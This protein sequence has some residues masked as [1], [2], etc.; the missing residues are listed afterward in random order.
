MTIFPFPDAYSTLNNTK[1]VDEE[2]YKQEAPAV[3]IREDQREENFRLDIN[4]WDIN[5]HQKPDQPVRSK[6]IWFSLS[7]FQRRDFIE[8]DFL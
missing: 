5:R 2:L 3:D 8:S 7:L 6:A 4:K 1:R